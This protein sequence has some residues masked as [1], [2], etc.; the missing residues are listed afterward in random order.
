M[1]FNRNLINAILE[2][3]HELR[4]TRHTMTQA[5]DNAK[6]AV[7]TLVAVCEK[8]LAALNAANTSNDPAFQAIADEAQAEIAKANAVLNPPAQPTA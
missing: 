3:T 8:L 4:R 2:L 1:F 6:A 7:D 5:S